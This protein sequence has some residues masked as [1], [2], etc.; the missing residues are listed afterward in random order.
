MIGQENDKYIVVTL[1]L[2]SFDES[3]REALRSGIAEFCNGLEELD[4]EYGFGK[5]RGY[6]PATDTGRTD[7]RKLK[8]WLRELEET[9]N[10]ESGEITETLHSEYL[11]GV[12]WVENWKK[13]YKPVRAGNRFVVYPSWEMPELSDGADL[14]IQLDPGRAFGT[15][16]HESTQLCLDLMESLTL[17]GYR[18]ADVGCGSGILSIAAV[19]LGAKCV[20]ACDTDVTAIEVA[21]ENSKTNRVFSR[22]TFQAG[23]VDSLKPDAPFDL[24]LA[25]ITGEVLMELGREL[26]GLLAENGKMIWSGIVWGVH[27][28]VQS[29]I[30]DISVNLISVRSQGDWY[31][32]LL[33]AKSSGAGE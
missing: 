3:L 1:D 2:H 13:Y 15:G 17:D 32:Y 28:E 7:L 23:S 8:R 5:I 24:I 10:L 20:T 4:T 26:S 31:A 16:H 12:D 22:I 25:N 33:G 21:R 11:T 14:P 27:R 6:L 29:Y 30:S 18:V 9:N 19:M